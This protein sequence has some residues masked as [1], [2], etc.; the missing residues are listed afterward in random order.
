MLGCHAEALDSELR[1]DPNELESA[2]WFDRDQVRQML[3]DSDSERSPRASSKIAI[4]H[5][6]IR[7]WVDG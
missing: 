1:I 5:H 3:A 7:A 4:A 6:L 2:H